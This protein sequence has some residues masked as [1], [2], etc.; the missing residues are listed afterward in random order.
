MKQGILAFLMISL[1]FIIPSKGEEKESIQN[2]KIISVKLFQ[3]QATI[4]RSINLHLEK[5]INHITIGNLPPLLY[6]WSVRGSLPSSYM[7]K[8]VSIEVEQKALVNKKQKQILEIEETLK[9]L[10]EKDRVHLDEIKSIASQDKFLDS[11]L[12]FTNQTASKELATRIP[13]IEVWDN[14]LN[15]VAGKKKILLARKREIELEREIIGKQIQKWEFELSQIAGT[16]YFTSYRSLNKAIL[17]NR[18]GVEIQQFDNLSDQYGQRR[19]LFENPTEKVDIEKRI[20]VDIHSSTGGATDFSFSYVIPNTSWQMKY[21]MRAD[22]IGNKID[23]VVYG[24][25]FQ[26]TGENWD[27]IALTLSTG[28]PVHSITPPILAPWY[29]DIDVPYR[30]GEKRDY[31]LEEE[32][33]KKEMKTADKKIYRKGNGKKK[34]GDNGDE[35]STEI[36]DK[37][38]YMEIS[39][40]V[41]QFIQS[42]AKFQKKFIKDFQIESR[43]GLKFYYEAIPA[44]VRNGY[45]KA[46]VTNNTGL[47][48]LS[49]EAQIFLDN[50]FMGK[51]TIPSV[52]SGKEEEF[53]LGNESRIS[54]KKEL[55]KK[56]ED[57]AGAFGGKRRIL[58]QYSLTVESQLPRDIELVIYDTIPVTR[59]DKI[60][61]VIKNLS[62]PFTR[63]E[64]FEKSTR[65]AQ[66]IRKWKMNIGSRRKIVISYELI[67]TFDKEL[68]IKGLR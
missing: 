8:I 59:N 44:E 12:D 16:S 36:R 17:N 61:V 31:Y 35:Y 50:E 43:S 53:V 7:G 48:W 15:Y 42:S 26:Q 20:I 65:Y 47:P 49:G 45:L 51:T 34:N 30:P 5:G 11:I 24:N 1:W 6:D 14:T 2:S 10:Q 4:V 13:Q 33:G 52:P 62:H 25:I 28:A 19:R 58:Y 9:A 60:E 56:F 68:I 32:T 67:V 23:M 37:G 29:L 41:R 63:D 46:I 66:G 38:P 27:N 64:I 21:D 57:T 18:G 3:N 40:P 55:V 54:S 22:S 39:I